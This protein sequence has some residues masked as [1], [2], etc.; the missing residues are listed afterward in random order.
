LNIYV[1]NF[2]GSR[3]GGYFERDE[4]VVMELVAIKE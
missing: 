1:N 4:V 3:F 2:F